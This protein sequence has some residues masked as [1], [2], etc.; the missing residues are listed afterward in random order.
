MVS[1]I[2]TGTDRSAIGYL[3]FYLSLITIPDIFAKVNSVHF[4]YL[5]SNG[6]LPQ[7]AKFYTHPETRVKAFSVERLNITFTSYGKRE[8]APRD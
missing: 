5:V 1:G 8:F 6:E 2:A 3:F 7:G 4:P